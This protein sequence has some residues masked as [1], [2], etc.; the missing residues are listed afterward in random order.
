MRFGVLGTADIATGRVIP[1]IQASEHEVTAIASRD[2]T[3]AEAVAAEMD[4]PRAVEGYGALLDLAKLEAVYVPLPNGL[5]AEWVRAAADAGLHVLCE[6]PL[7]GSA[8]ETAALFDYCEERDVVLMEAFMYRFHPRTERA[9]DIVREELGT[10]T[11]VASTFT[12]RMPE[13]VA[14]IRLDPDLAGGSVMDVGC[15]PVSAAR[16][17]L[18]EPD[19]VYAATADTRD[20]GVDSR[21]SA[22]LEYDAGATAT[23]TSG[24]DSPETQYYRVGATDGWL[25]AEPAFNVGADETVELTWG[26]D[27]HRTTETFDAVDDY[28]REVEHFAECVETGRAPRVDREESEE[29][30]RIIDAIYESAA[31]GQPVSAD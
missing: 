1:A 9:L 25:Q 12:F 17:F 20:A 24:F 30:M 4:V 13:G 2:G 27:G 22:V 31:T 15:Y 23:L 21:M 26:V 10:V 5:H 8:E 19:W 7:T 29:I 28:R 16:L 14:D 11:S 18:G 6:K 3:R